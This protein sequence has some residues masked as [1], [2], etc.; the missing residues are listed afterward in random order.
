MMINGSHQLIENNTATR[1][2]DF[3]TN[4][5]SHTVYRGNVMHDTTTADC[6]PHSSNCH[7]DFIESEPEVSGGGSGPAAY[8]L[9][10]GNTQ[11]NNLGS[12]AHSFLTQGDACNGQCSHVIERFNLTA[13]EGSAAGNGYGI[14]DD[15]GAFTYIKTYNNTSAFMGRAGDTTDTYDGASTNNATKNSLYYYSGSISLTPYAVITSSQPGGTWSNNLAWCTGSC[16]FNPHTYGSGAWT[17]DPGN[18]QKDPMF[19]DVSTDNYRL[20]AGSPAIG[21]GTYLTTTAGTGTSS[22]SL[23]V[24]DASFFFDGAGIVT[25]D[26][27]RIGAST[28]A[29]IASIDYAANVITLATPVS[30]TAGAGVYLYKDSTGRVVLSGANPDIGAFPSGGGITSQPPG[31]PSNLQV[32]V[33]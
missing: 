30:W 8:N 10:E 15:L 16:T 31:A 27:V 29:Q 33:H 6:G 9:Y 3:S 4:F 20:Q 13:H 19:V 5:A 17:N 2:A 25:A 32:F 1:T 28:T 12:N 11:L 23:T 22:T 14:L 18:V 26:W 21:A 7:I 24:A